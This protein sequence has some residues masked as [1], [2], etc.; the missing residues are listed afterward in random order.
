MRRVWLRAV[1]W[2]AYLY[3]L[4][5]L[6]VCVL[7]ALLVSWLPRR[8]RERRVRRMINWLSYGLVRWLCFGGALELELSGIETLRR[9]KGVIIAANHPTFLDAIF[10]FSFIEQVFC[11]VKSSVRRNPL[12]GP[13][14]GTAGYVSIDH[15]RRFIEESCRRLH[16]H[17]TLLVFPEGTRSPVAGL[18]RFKP[19]FAHAAV[20]AGAPVVTVHIESGC[21]SFLRKNEPIV[22][23]WQ[24]LPLRYSFRL[25]A[26]FA[27]A[28]GETA[29]AFLARVE[30]YFQSEHPT[31]AEIASVK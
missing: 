26:E 21:G 9:A 30:S 6:V 25:G 28:S 8:R 1:L 13:S 15:P 4:I 12:L 20:R 17:E 14:V 24:P 2:S 11:V 29:A 31:A 7:F 3:V 5:G 19:G 18:H 16:D 23:W 10:L 27:P 22:S